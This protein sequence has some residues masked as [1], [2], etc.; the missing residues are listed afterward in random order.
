MTKSPVGIVE[1]SPATY[2][3]RLSAYGWGGILTKILVNQYRHTCPV[4]FCVQFS[5]DTIDQL[6]R[7]RVYVTELLVG[8]P[9]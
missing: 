4:D 7:E 9:S 1:A 2:K 5:A 8:V 3:Y 6:V